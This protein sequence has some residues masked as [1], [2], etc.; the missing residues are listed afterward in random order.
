MLSSSSHPHEPIC[1][2]FATS[3]RRRSAQDR[4]ATA[5]DTRR[6]RSRLGTHDGARRA[7]GGCDCHGQSSR[8]REHAGDHRA[9]HRAAVCRKG[10]TRSAKRP[11]DFPGPGKDAEHGAR[12]SHRHKPGGEIR[13]TRRS[14]RSFGPAPRRIQLRGTRASRGCGFIAALGRSAPQCRT[15]PESPCRSKPSRH[16]AP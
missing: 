5:A 4:A 3:A 7:G 14:S 11:I 1:K 9:S 2:H 12:L 8:S 16:T 10:L 13:P 15:C 6:H